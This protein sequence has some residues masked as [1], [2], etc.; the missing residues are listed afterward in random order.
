MPAGAD[1]VD[2]AVEGEVDGFGGVRAVVG[3]ELVVR[4]EDG[5]SLLLLVKKRFG[6][7]VFL[8]KRRCVQ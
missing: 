5:A 4:E 1:I 3:G 7:I 2:S 8:S 6:Q